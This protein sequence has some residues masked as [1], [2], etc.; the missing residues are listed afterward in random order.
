[1][2]VV[3]V[4]SGQLDAAWRRW[5]EFKSGRLVALNAALAKAGRPQI[6]IP[7]PDR[8]QIGAPDRGQDLP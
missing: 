4:A 6:T 5:S 1:V 2:Q 3:S 7:P 8:L